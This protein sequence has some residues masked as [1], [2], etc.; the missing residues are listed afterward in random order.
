MTKTEAETL[1]VKW[2]QQV[3]LS[4][5]KRS[6]L[7]SESIGEG[8]LRGN[9]HYMTC[10]QSRAKRSSPVDRGRGLVSGNPLEV[11]K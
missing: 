6:N 9:Y 1:R 5:C 11:S 8:S 3:D 4:A 10:G 2:K 7:E